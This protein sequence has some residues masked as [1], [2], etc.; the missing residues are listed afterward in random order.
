MLVDIGII[1]KENPEDLSEFI[2]KNCKDL[3]PDQLGEFFGKEDDWCIETLSLF[4]NKLDFK[5]LGLEGAMKA[6]LVYFTL[7]GEG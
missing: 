6:Y 2:F 1:R 7:P 4:T 5:K 3:N